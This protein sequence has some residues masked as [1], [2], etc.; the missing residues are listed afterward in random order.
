MSCTRSALVPGSLGFRSARCTACPCP[1]LPLVDVRICFT[2]NNVSQ[3][4]IQ[5]GCP[6]PIIPAGVLLDSGSS[7]PTVSYQ[8]GI[9][10]DSWGKTCRNV[11]WQ[12]SVQGDRY[13]RIRLCPAADCASCTDAAP[14]NSAGQSIYNS[15]NVFTVNSQNL[16]PALT[17]L[18]QDW[19]TGSP[20]F[21][22]AIA[23]YSYVDCAGACVAS[24][25]TCGLGPSTGFPTNVSFGTEIVV[26]PLNELTPLLAYTAPPA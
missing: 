22:P 21:I 24:Y 14:V 10:E 6:T 20:A 23:G 18:A 16:L 19:G 15:L 26:G 4:V 8:S 25:G 2:V 7:A 1:L 11:V 13:I 12:R 5:Q 17:L 9:T 3:V